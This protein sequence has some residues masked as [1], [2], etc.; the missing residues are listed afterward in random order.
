MEPL[1]PLPLS[2]WQSCHVAQQRG[3][4]RQ[5]CI[6]SPH[7]RSTVPSSSTNQETGCGCELDQSFSHAMRTLPH[8]VSASNSSPAVVSVRPQMRRWWV[9]RPVPHLSHGEPGSEAI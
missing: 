4:C 7:G 3:S 5:R 1:G 6:A 9:L 2:R 8:A